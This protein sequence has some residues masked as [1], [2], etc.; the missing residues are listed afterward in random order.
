MVR[1][2]SLRLHRIICFYNLNCV[3]FSMLSQ[4]LVLVKSLEYFASV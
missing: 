4:K 3:K 1:H 2:F